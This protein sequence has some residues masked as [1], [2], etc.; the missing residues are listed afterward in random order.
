M[1]NRLGLSAFNES[2]VLVDDEFNQNR[3]PRILSIAI[4]NRDGSCGDGGRVSWLQ[5]TVDV[6]VVVGKRAGEC[7][8]CITRICSELG[9][10]N[11]KSSTCTCSGTHRRGE[12]QRRHK[13]LDDWHVDQLLHV[14]YVRKKPYNT[15]QMSEPACLKRTNIF[16]EDVYFLGFK[17]AH[18]ISLCA[19]SKKRSQPKCAVFATKE[20]PGAVFVHASTSCSPRFFSNRKSARTQ[21]DALAPIRFMP[22]PKPFSPYDGIDARS[23]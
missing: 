19:L 2:L 13:W 9:C 18:T 5:N 6:E 14:K 22:T 3:R 4:W 12:A 8:S 17:P 11:G 20:N 21:P 15:Y 1:Y 23:P 16:W 7:G 10:G